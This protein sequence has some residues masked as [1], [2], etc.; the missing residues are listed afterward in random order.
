MA[1]IADSI[2]VTFSHGFRVLN[3]KIKIPLRH[4]SQDMLHSIYLAYGI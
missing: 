4:Q 2:S 3:I 1:F